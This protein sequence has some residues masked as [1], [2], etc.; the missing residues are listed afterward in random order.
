MDALVLLGS[1]AVLM[2]I[3]MPVAYAL[4]GAALI[5][6]MWIDLP[7]DGVVI[8]I[9]SGVNKFSLLAIAC[10]VLAGAIMV[11]MLVTYVP[12]ISLW[13]PRLIGV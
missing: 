1:F 10:F 7:V 3:G 12:A 5:G 11:L 8:Q 2:M 9:A 6:A 13:L 4:G